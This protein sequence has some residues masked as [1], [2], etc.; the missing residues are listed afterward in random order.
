MSGESQGFLFCLKSDVLLWFFP[1][2]TCVW[3]KAW[4]F[5]LLEIRCIVVVFPHLYMCLG[6]AKDFYFA[7]NQMYC[8]G[9]SPLIH[10]S[11]ES[12]GFLFCLKSDV[13]LWFSP[14]IHVSGE[15]QG[16]LFCLKS[17]VLLWFFPT[18]TC[19]SIIYI[20]TK[21]HSAMEFFT[22]NTGSLSRST[23]TKQLFF[24]SS[25]F[26][27]IWGLRL[28]K[29]ISLILSRVNHKM[30]RKREIPQKIHLTTCKQNLVC[31]TYDPS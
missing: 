8:C 26:F 29:I 17:D 11:G 24:F 7:W 25:F 31:F 27:F 14:L 22:V 10:V 4:I 3:G 5:I 6:K 30:G 13:L 16:F 2:Y 18:F 28:L 15:S 12:Q 20:Y 19:F 23:M 1:A 21:Q 9:F